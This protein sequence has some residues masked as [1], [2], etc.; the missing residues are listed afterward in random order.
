MK[1]IRLS[2]DGMTCGHCVTNVRAALAK[3]PGTVVESVTV[4]S[5]SLRAEQ[6]NVA[7]ALAALQDA[8]Y[9][10]TVVDAANEAPVAS[11]CACCAPSARD[12]APVDH[13][14]TA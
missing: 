9:S 10:A 12:G 3:V 8:G 11:G 1:T 4:G 2:I 5:A 7:P 6:A 13:C 14:A